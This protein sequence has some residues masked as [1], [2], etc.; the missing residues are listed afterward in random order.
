MGYVDEMRVC[1][2]LWRLKGSCHLLADAAE[3]LERFA[4]KLKLRPQ[5][6]HGDHYDLT[7]NKRM[8]AIRLGA[9]KVT[10]REMVKI[11]CR[12]ERDD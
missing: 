6:R 2:P 7:A 5:Y 10:S 1:G 3:E 8:Q 11:R 12:A 9:V 4:R